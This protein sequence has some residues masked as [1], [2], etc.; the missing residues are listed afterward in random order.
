MIIEGG[1][2]CGSVRY[3]AEGEPLFRLQCHCRECQYISGGG[4]N[5]VMG[6]PAPGFSYTQGQPRDFARSDL[7]SPVTRQ[8]CPTCGTHLLTTSP[9]VPDAVLLKV[10]TFDDPAVF[11]K[12]SMAIF[13]VDKQA[14]HCIPD[15]LPLHERRPS[16][17]A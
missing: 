4:P 14:F 16:S 3:R 5:V 7:P 17:Y 1:C 11:G 13:G 12:P 8:F 2:Y 10:G 9:R 15:D 6:M